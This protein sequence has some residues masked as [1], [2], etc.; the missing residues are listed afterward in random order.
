MLTLY[1]S[2]GACSMAPHIALEEAGARFDAKAISLKRGDQRQPAYLAL[3]PKGKVP[4]LLVDGR[5]LTENL[6]I[7]TYI[8]RT[9]PEAKLLPAGNPEAE[10]QAASF[11]AWLTATVHPTLGRFFG[12][13]RYTDLP[14]SADNVKKLAAQQTAES[15]ALIEKQLEGR[16]WALGDYSV[17]DAYLYVFQRWARALQL[18]LAPFENYNAHYERMEKRPAVRR[19]LEREEKAQ[20]DL[21]KAA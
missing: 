11:L 4:L 10:A 18:D 14:N 20:L 19:M 9:H 17:A 6:A 5:P 12:P 3:N 2:P 15:F 16:D 7:L 1:Y 21:E 8:A 13:Q